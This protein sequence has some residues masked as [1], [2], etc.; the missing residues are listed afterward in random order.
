MGQSELYRV[1]GELELLRQ[2]SGE[3]QAERCF[4]TAIDIAR[5]QGAKWWELRAT[6]S[7]AR[8]LKRQGKTDEALKTLAEVYNWITEGF[9]TAALREPNACFEEL[10]PKLRPR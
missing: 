1:Q 10:T 3:A 4:R 9:D 7:L 2:T 5:H 6:V 8:L